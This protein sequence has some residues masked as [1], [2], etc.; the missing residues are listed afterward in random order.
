M[1]EELQVIVEE[2]KEEVQVVVEEMKEEG[3]VVVEEMKEEGQVVGGGGDEGGGTGDSGGGEGGGTGGSGG[4]EGGGTGGSGGGEG[5]P[6]P[7]FCHRPPGGLDLTP[8]DD[9]WEGRA[10]AAVTP[11]VLHVIRAA[12]TEGYRWESDLL[13]GCPFCACCRKKMI[14][15][16][17]RWWL[18]RGNKKG[19][20]M[21][22][23][24]EGILQ[25]EIDEEVDWEDEENEEEVDWEDEE[26]E[27][28]VDWEDEEKGRTGGTGRT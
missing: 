7:S 26:N 1:K 15:R 18:K 8:N 25:E 13:G 27:E 9:G 28:E 14:D 10:A 22:R 20:R 23:R 3:Q 2:V 5:S 17:S 4:G 11:A 12:W 21:V 24:D 19:W 6:R 16:R